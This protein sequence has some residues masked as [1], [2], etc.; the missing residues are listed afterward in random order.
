ML[1]GVARR[2][3]DSPPPATNG[4]LSTTDALDQVPWGPARQGP[5][6]RLL[7]TPG[8]AEMLRH[9]SACEAAWPLFEAAFGIEPPSW[10]ADLPGVTGLSIVVFEDPEAGDAWLARIPGV[11]PEHL[12]FAKPL[13]A[14]LVP[15]RPA[16]LVKSNEEGLRVEAGARLVLDCMVITRLGVTVKRAWASQ[17]LS[18]YLIWPLTGTRLIG[19]TTAYTSRYAPETVGPGNPLPTALPADD[20]LKAG[21]LLVTGPEKPDFRLMVGKDLPGLTAPEMLYA[22]C[23]IAWLLEGRSDVAVPFLQAVGKM[24]EVDVE[25][26]LVEHL[27]MD[28]VDL[29]ARVRRWLE[30]TT[31]LSLPV[32]TTVPAPVP[33]VPAD[34]PK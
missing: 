34:P 31:A 2:A 4:T 28:I 29:E 6:V 18:D 21:L 7:G 11:P 20:W 15:G 30:E 14:S 8:D 16:I 10:P 27:G 13:A 33:P 25:P 26:L 9:Y 24:A 23:V 32:T 5:H 17:A 3:L 19:T 12:E 1:R 22:Y